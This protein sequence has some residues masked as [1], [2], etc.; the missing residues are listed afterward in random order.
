TPGC[1]LWPFPS[2]I[3]LTWDP[4]YDTGLGIGAWVSDCYDNGTGCFVQWSVQCVISG[5]EP[6]FM[7]NNG[8]EDAD[9]GHTCDPVFAVW[10]LTPFTG[11]GVTGGAN[12][13]PTPH[14]G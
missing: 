13:G 14:C 7:L 2:P 12:P 6:V 10:G 5:G 4:T 8:P 3:P 1:A 9:P 11:I